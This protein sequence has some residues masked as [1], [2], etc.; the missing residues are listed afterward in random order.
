VLGSQ[1][2]SLRGE[3]NHGRCIRCFA[4][5]LSLLVIGHDEKSPHWST[6]Q[7]RQRSELLRSRGLVHPCDLGSCDG[8]AAA[9]R[10]RGHSRDPRRYARTRA[11]YTVPVGTSGE[12]RGPEVASVASRSSPQTSSSISRIRCAA[13]AAR[14]LAVGAAVRGKRWRVKQIFVADAW[15]SEA[16]NMGGKLSVRPGQPLRDRRR[17]HRAVLHRHGRQTACADKRR[18]SSAR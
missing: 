11:E 17:S 13:N 9:R 15:G 18:A 14:T 3:R 8:Q 1:K 6:L 12:H 16:G 5:A 10:K 7:G 4:L 2:D